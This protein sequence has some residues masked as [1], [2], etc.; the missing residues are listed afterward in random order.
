MLMAGVALDPGGILGWI[1]IG[2]LAGAIASHLVRGR[3]L[4]C[5]LDV[6]VGV[7]GAFIGGLVV[8]LFVPHGT[9][10]GFWG[11]LLVAILGAVLLLALLRLVSRR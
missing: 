1:V 7:V 3:G 11:S 5:L 8:S 2:L 4:G 10:Y 9:A 6:V